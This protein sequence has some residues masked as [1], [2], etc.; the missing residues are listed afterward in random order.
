MVAAKCSVH[1]FGS[2][3]SL[4][5]WF[6]AGSKT[7]ERLSGL[8]PF[9]L[10]DNPIPEHGLPSGV[11]YIEQSFNDMDEPGA[12]PSACQCVASVF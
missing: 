3:L 6:S 12:W 2:R 4:C 1:L 8:C 7:T 11:N 10:H 9:T 5:K